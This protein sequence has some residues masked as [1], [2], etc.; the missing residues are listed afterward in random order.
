MTRKELDFSW[1]IS[2]PFSK[3]QRQKLNELC[4]Q[5]GSPQD[6][7]K[8][9]HITG[10]NGKGS[11]CTMLNSILQEAGYK[12]GLFTSPPIY[13]LNDQIKINNQKISD[14]DII[15]LE[16][17]IRKQAIYLN[18]LYSWSEIITAIALIYFYRNNCDIVIIE[19]II[20]GDVDPTN[21]ISNPLLSIITKVAK[22]HLNILGQSIEEIT[23]Q[24]SGIIKQNCPILFGEP[25]NN[26][27]K[28]I[29]QHRAKLK[30][31]DYYE[32]NLKDLYD[33]NYNLNLTEFSYKDYNDI[34]LSMLGT[35]QPINAAIVI[36][37][38]EILN[39]QNILINKKNIYDGLKK[40][41]YECRF[42][43]IQKNPLII[44]DG[45]HTA[46]GIQFIVDSIYQYFKNQKIYIF[47]TSFQGKD[48]YDMAIKISEIASK[49]FLFKYNRP[50]AISPSLLAQCFTIDN[51]KI[52][53]SLEEGFINAKNEAEKDGAIL[54]CLGAFSTYPS[55]QNILKKGE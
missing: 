26:K 21:I 14:E 18:N 37:A 34:K 7:L 1:E 17:E 19:A 52:L 20:G 49:V 48:Y 51:I 32:I 16:A 31:S 11:V 46:D 13:G 40:S 3:I 9:I 38:I 8:Y 12:V 27:A 30:N 25:N 44:F 45:A 22:D 24:K 5:F 36:S 4:N 43:I 47:M 39:Q 2:T 42:E 23:L 53:N 55:I 35:Y 6:K 15:S 50:D 10:T 33:I 54:L 29:L 41:H 28:T